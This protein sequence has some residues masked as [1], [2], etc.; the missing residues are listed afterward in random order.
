[1]VIHLSVTCSGGYLF[2]RDWIKRTA[3]IVFYILFAISL[4]A[5]AYLMIR[6]GVAGP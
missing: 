1:M 2:N 4:L 5:T 3:R 6:A